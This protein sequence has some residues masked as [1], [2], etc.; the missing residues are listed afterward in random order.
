MKQLSLVVFFL[1]A[2]TGLQAQKLTNDKVPGAVGSAFRT[3]FPQAQQDSWWKVDSNYVS[4]F[5]NQKKTQSATFTGTG[6]WL[7]TETLITPNQL[8]GAVNRAFN[9][10]FEG[11]SVQDIYMVEKPNMV[12]T[13]VITAFKGTD[14][15]ELEFGAK[16]ELIR[17]DM[18]ENEE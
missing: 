5:Y 9:S 16:G 12:A 15:Y 13:Y 3:R 2:Y 10:Q 18:F 11:F 7:K 14:N 4:Q 6:I 1:L 17:K 8:P